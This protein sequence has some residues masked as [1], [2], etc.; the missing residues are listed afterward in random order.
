[1]AELRGTLND[2]WPEWTTGDARRAAASRKL[3]MFGENH[4]PLVRAKIAE[5]IDDGRTAGNVERFASRSPN[6]LRAVGSAIAVAYRSGCRRELRGASPE[7]AQAFADLVAE[8]GIAK[9]APGINARSWAAGPHIVAPHFTR[10]G[11]LALD[12][13][14]PDRVD[15]RRDGD[16]LDAVLW[17]QGGTFVLLDGEAWR[18]FDQDGEE[19]GGDAVYHA[20]GVCP[21]VP[22]ISAD[23]GDDFWASAARNGLA[24]ATLTIAAKAAWGLFI[25][26]TH[27][28]PLVSIIADKTPPGQVLGHPVAPLVLADAS[29][30]VQVDD[31]NIVPAA[32]YLSEISALIA[33]AVSAEGLPPGSVTMSA[34]DWGSLG[35]NVE[36]PRLAAHRDAQVQWLRD[37]ERAL[38]VAV[39]DVVRGS[40]HRH[41]RRMPPGDE[42]RDMLRVNFPDLS[43][44]AEQLAR[45]EAMKAGLPFGLSNPTDIILQAQPEVSPN[46]ADETRAGNLEDYIATIDPLV[47]RNIPADAPEARGVQTIAQEQGRAGGQASGQT[48]AAQAQE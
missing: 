40:T 6:L 39:A 45:I 13:V 8:C 24:D 47:R 9:K 32:N 2:L 33:M 41:A 7:V 17:M 16:D 30:K 38:W 22:F 26:Q 27:S 11:K 48:R 20:A 36:G 5:F 3:A 44:P 28:T 15:V 18:Y 4:L 43:T 37:S 35:L 14:G 10:R 29:E 34:N 1:M 23:G 46:E 31:D 42:I 19:I 25:Q 12:I 21:A